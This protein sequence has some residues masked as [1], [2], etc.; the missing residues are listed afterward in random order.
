M[1]QFVSVMIACYFVI[2]LDTFVFHAWLPLAGMLRY[3]LF[4]FYLLSAP[5]FILLGVLAYYGS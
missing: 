1:R 4:D 2:C 5:L 3:A